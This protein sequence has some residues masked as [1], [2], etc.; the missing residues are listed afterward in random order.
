MSQINIY[1]V[2]EP[3]EDPKGQRVNAEPNKSCLED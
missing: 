3:D 1:T 2:V